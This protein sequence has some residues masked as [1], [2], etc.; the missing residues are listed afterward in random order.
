[1]FDQSPAISLSK[2]LAHSRKRLAS[3]SLCVA[4]LAFPACAQMPAW[5]RAWTLQSYDCPQCSPQDRDFLHS[6]LGGKVLLLPE[7]FS[8][9]T[10]EGCL[11]LPDYRD[12]RPRSPVDARQYLGNGRLP[13][14]SAGEPLAGLVRCRDV[15]GTPNVV[16]RIVIDGQRAF[17]L[18]E[19][20]A[21]LNLR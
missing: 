9:P 4:I 17:L 18:H 2:P 6:Q 11:D 5:Q 19:S 14:L 3:L 21:V 20:G 7:K 10:Y 13:A 16:A 12:I 1:M 15:S 8:N